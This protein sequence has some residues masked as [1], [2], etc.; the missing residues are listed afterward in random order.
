[1]SGRKH[2]RRWLELVY[3]LALSACSSGLVP[4]TPR[5]ARGAGYEL[6]LGTLRG[7]GGLRLDEEER[8]LELRVLAIPP[9]T[10]V[11]AASVQAA[12]QPVCSGG[13]AATRVHVPGGP[14]TNRRRPK[15]GETLRVDLPGAAWKLA[16]AA[17]SRLD[18]VLR[19]ADGELQCASFALVDGAPEY[20]WRALES[21]SVSGQFRVEFFPD[22]VAGLDS[23]A[24]FGV[25]L[26]K[27]L[28]PLRVSA[29][30]GAGAA[31]CTR[32]DC[33]PDPGD[34]PQHYYLPVFA[35]L[36]ATLFQTGRLAFELAA[37]YKLA[38]T[39]TQTD[40]G[41]RGALLHGPELM[42]RF[43]WALPDPIAP[44]IPGGPRRGY[45]VSVAL[46]MG[47][48]MSTRGG[49]SVSVGG[50]LMFSFPIY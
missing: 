49:A 22:R 33:R 4:E 40:A 14:W 25:A 43:A 44:G 11:L 41:E 48:I 17:P 31:W 18:V 34:A 28:G 38:W 46:P 6:Q 1:M 19:D 5:I 8:Q 45:A 27:W 37:Q 12:T 2:P 47:Y 16:T 30:G 21:W 50:G 3:L 7:G 24:F 36:D 39:E 35:G 42:P 9:R 26:G 29:G 13:I 15:P 32:S 20:R 10:R 23:A